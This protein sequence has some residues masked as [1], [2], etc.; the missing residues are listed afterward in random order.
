[1]IN[2]YKFGT[3]LLIGP[4]L[5]PDLAIDRERNPFNNRNSTGH[6]YATKHA[7]DRKLPAIG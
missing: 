3:Y 5:C 6:Q 1:M 7:P 2:N 4:H